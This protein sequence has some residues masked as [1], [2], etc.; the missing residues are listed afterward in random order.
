MRET[1][2]V[3]FDGVLAQY[4]GWKGEETLGKPNPG[5]VGFVKDLIEEGYEVAIHTTR[6]C[7]R[8]QEWLQLWSLDHPSVYPTREKP[9]ALI[10]IDDRGYRFNGDFHAAF[11][12]IHE[13]TWWERLR[14]RRVNSNDNQQQG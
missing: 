10:Y 14:D 4:D 6:D 7:G 12:A 1:V 2:C 11:L 3:D 9:P 5:A 8:I 13:P